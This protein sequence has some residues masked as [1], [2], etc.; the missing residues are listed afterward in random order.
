MNIN[1]FLRRLFHSPIPRLATVTLF[2][3]TW[4]SLA[5]CGEIHDAAKAGDLAKVK[6]LLKENPNLVLSKEYKEGRTSLHMAALDL[7]Q[8][9]LDHSR[10]TSQFIEL[11]EGFSVP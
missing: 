8:A 7:K 4:S 3:L 6:A 10:E 2:A 9:R 5:F 1:T 11:A